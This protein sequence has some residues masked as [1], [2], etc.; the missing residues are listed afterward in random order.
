MKNNSC[1]C[2]A[3]SSYKLLCKHRK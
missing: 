3:P 2:R 1:S